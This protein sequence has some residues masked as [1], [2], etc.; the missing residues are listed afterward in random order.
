MADTLHSEQGVLAATS[1]PILDAVA[2][3]TTETV[4][5]LSLSNISGTSAD[6]TVDLSITKQGGS[7]RKILNDVSLPFG[8]TI[9]I[10]TKFVLEHNDTMQGLASAASSVDFNVAYL[11]QL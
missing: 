4:I 10:D 1:T 2:A 3:S 8:T 7:L 9:T 5:G 6:V 11:K